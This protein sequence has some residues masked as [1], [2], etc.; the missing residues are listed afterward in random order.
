[1]KTN[2]QL[3]EDATDIQKKRLFQL[4]TPAEIV[5]ILRQL[6]RSRALHQGY[7]DDEILMYEL[8]CVSKLK[9]N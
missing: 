3:L 8:L 2:E 1:M 5:P 7:R 9:G 6:D 4:F